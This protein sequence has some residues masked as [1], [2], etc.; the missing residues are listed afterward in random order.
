MDFY[1]LVEGP[2]LWVAFLVL[3]VSVFARLVFFVVSIVRSSGNREGSR[4]LYIPVT[5]ARLF[6]PFHKAVAKRPVYAILRYVFH[7]CLFVVPIW[8]SGHI[9]LWE[10]SRF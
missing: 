2:L 6:V 7:V 9:S 10:D 5:L 4:A 8:L 3:V 1:S